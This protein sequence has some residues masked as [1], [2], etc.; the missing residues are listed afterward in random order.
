MADREPVVAGL[1]SERL[2][3]LAS[4]QLAQRNRR[5][6]ALGA[7][8]S[9]FKDEM[10]YILRPFNP[11]GTTTT[12]SRKNT[13]RDMITPQG[14]AGKS[15]AQL[16][17]SRFNHGCK[18][19]SSAANKSDQMTLLFSCSKNSPQLPYRGSTRPLR[20]Y[21]A[22]DQ[23]PQ[24]FCTKFQVTDPLTGR[25]E[26]MTARRPGKAAAETNLSNF[27]SNML[28]RERTFSLM[29]AKDNIDHDILVSYHLTETVLHDVQYRFSQKR[30]E[31]LYCI[32]LISL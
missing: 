19:Q 7:E 32:S 1:P 25:T 21:I 2:S 24:A 22:T 26:I 6:N 5:E 16:N 20:Q 9:A 31:C 17:N 11:S 13:A 27:D 28:P 3:Q 18:K 23:L 4:P 29:K 30:N 14:Y 12:S 8:H 10:S 15:T